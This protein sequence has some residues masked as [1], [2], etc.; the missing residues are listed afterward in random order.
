MKMLLL[1]NLLA[2]YNNQISFFLKVSL[3][4]PHQNWWNFPSVTRHRPCQDYCRLIVVQKKGISAF[5]HVG[6]VTEISHNSRN[7]D[8]HFRQT[9]VSHYRDPGSVGVQAEGCYGTV[10]RS[11]DMFLIHIVNPESDGSPSWLWWSRFLLRSLSQP[12]PSPLID[13]RA[14]IWS[15]FIAST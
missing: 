4:T 10:L 3:E 9:S 6:W 5:R 11:F 14:E 12:P 8:R 2:S 1:P 13:Q 7:F 15:S